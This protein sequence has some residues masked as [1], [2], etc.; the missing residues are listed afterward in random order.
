[1]VLVVAMQSQWVGGK[2]QWV[3]V[4]AVGREMTAVGK[5]G[6]EVVGVVDCTETVGE[7]EEEEDSGLASQAA[8]RAKPP[9]NSDLLLLDYVM[10]YA[11]V[12]AYFISCRTTART[13]GKPDSRASFTNF[14][15]RNA[16]S[17]WQMAEVRLQIPFSKLEMINS[18]CYIVKY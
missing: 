13:Y 17:I 3:A 4:S 11:S 9:S 16:N 10:G 8:T 1:M 6:E 14:T 15:R 12:G 18:F 7:E 2:R 5:T